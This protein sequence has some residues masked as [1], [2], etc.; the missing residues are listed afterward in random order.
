MKVLLAQRETGN[1][2]KYVDMLQALQVDFGVSID[3]KE[4]ALYDKL[5]LPGGWDIDPKYYGENNTACE[6]IDIELDKGQFQLL[7][8]FIQE[9]KPV[10]GI[11]RGCQIM[12]VYFG[13]TLIQDLPTATQHR[14]LEGNL[15]NYHLVTSIENSIMDS[16]YGR[17]FRVN[18]THH[19][20]CGK[21]GQGLKVSLLAP[22]GVVEAIEHEKV[23]AFAVQWHP[24][25][26]GFLTG[27][28]E[29]KTANG[30]KVLE[31]FL[32]IYGD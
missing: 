17:E 19:Q 30:K 11:C 15:D 22:D 6:N 25:R 26:M 5:L 1:I 29:S 7:D 24:E 3:P 28:K 31:Y 21:I 14:A 4:A 32:N 23:E 12:N 16:I 10:F 2:R 13:G 9:G 27:S 18:S 20:G 8:A